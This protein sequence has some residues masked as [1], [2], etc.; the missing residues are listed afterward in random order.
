MTDTFYLKKGG[1]FLHW[2]GLCF[3]DDE[4]GAWIGTE[5]HRDAFC[6][7]RRRNALANARG[8]EMVKAPETANAEH[9][10]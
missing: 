4:T 9:A 6:K 5:Q 2:T 8:V 10:A 3:T 1:K 7:A